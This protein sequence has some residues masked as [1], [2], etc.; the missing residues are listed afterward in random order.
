MSFNTSATASINPSNPIPV[1]AGLGGDAGVGFHSGGS[2]SGDA[3]LTEQKQFKAKH[4]EA[5]AQPSE[6]VATHQKFLE[7]PFTRYVRRPLSDGGEPKHV[8]KHK[9]EDRSTMGVPLNP[10]WIRNDHYSMDKE[11]NIFL[12]PDDFVAPVVT[13]KGAQSVQVSTK[14]EALL[15]N[16]EQPQR[17]GDTHK[18]AEDNKLAPKDTI[19]GSAATKIEEAG[20]QQIPDSNPEEVA[21]NNPAAGPTPDEKEEPSKKKM[22]V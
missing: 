8:F 4:T 10:F 5:N 18:I 22:K 17:G 15:D 11:A 3:T 9:P 14:R 19:C 7:S 16:E 2:F 13:H 1:P 20:K 21:E 6:A 12:Q